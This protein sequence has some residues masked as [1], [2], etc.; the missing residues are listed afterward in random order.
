MPVQETVTART[1]SACGRRPMTSTDTSNCQ[2]PALKRQLEQLKTDNSSLRKEFEQLKQLV[3]RQ[4]Q[5]QSALKRES[6]RLRDENIGAS[7]LRLLLTWHHNYLELIKARAETTS[8]INRMR[9][10]VDELRERVETRKSAGTE[11]KRPTT[12]VV[13]R[14]SPTEP[15]EE[16]S[17]SDNRTFLFSRA[18][19]SINKLVASQKLNKRPNKNGEQL[20]SRRRA[21]ELTRF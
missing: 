8:I 12:S 3:T 15:S 6:E 16:R 1:P 14:E 2:C 9:A 13:E 5:Q 7:R 21:L 17:T 19:A 20:R 4:G 10:E 18:S 11:N